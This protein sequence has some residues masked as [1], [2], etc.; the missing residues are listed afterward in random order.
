MRFQVA[1][2]VEGPEFVRKCGIAGEAPGAVFGGVATVARVVGG[3]AGAEVGGVADVA[4][5]RV[6]DALEDV[7]VVH[8]C[9]SARGCWW[10]AG[11]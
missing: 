10:L 8:G 5:V 7:D 9:F 2:E 6:G 4:L 3:E 11:I 1:L